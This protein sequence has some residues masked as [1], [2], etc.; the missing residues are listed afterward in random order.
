LSNE[1]SEAL[2]MSEA[3][4]LPKAMPETAEKATT[5]SEFAATKPEPQQQVPLPRAE[6]EKDYKRKVGEENDLPVSDDG[7]LTRP[8]LSPLGAVSATQEVEEVPPAPIDAEALDAMFA[9]VNKELAL[10]DLSNLKL[11]G[12]VQLP[13]DNS[14]IPNTTLE[15]TLEGESIV[16]SI[17]SSEAAV[18]K[19]CEE[20]LEQ[21]AAQ[22]Q[23]EQKLTVRVEPA[24][25]APLPEA[26]P[27]SRDSS[28]RGDG[29]QQQAEQSSSQ[30][31]NDKD[32]TKG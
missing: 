23:G 11:G 6:D 25:T 28:G 12:K 27:S 8:Q 26:Q 9:A 13:L 15:L 14:K 2:E 5:K 10:R 1:M 32:Q 17:R 19:F 20:N 21:M 24:L 30:E 16:L 29:R 7:D 4:D 31:D 18:L 3:S 22:L